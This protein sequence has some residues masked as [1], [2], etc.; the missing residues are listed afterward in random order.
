[1]RRIDRLTRRGQPEERQSLGGL[2]D[3]IMSFMGHGYGLGLSPQMTWGNE[4]SEPIGG[5]F[6]GLADQALKANPIVFTCVDARMRLFTEARFKFRGF[7][8]GRPGDL[9][10]TPALSLL[11]RP[12]A[13]GTTGDL[14]A[15]MEL[16]DSLAGNFFATVTGA[17]AEKRIVVLRPDWCDLVFDLDPNDPE[18]MCVGLAYKPGGPASKL[19]ARFYPAGSFIHYAPTPDPLAR[20]RGMSWLTPVIREIQA[21]SAATR[22]KGKFFDNA[23]TPNLAVSLS[24]KVTVDAFKKFVEI[25]EDRGADGGIEQAY[26][27]LWLAG[28]ADV[29]V[30]GTD[31]GKLD[32]KALTGAGETR[33][34]AAAG[35]PPIVGNFSEGLEAA[36]YSNYA[37]ARRA[38]GDH[39][40]RPRWRNAAASLAPLVTVPAGTELWYD[41]RDIAFLREDRKDAAEIA[42]L[43]AATIRQYVDAGFDPASAVAAVENEDPRLLS[44]TGLYSVQLQAPGAATPVPAAP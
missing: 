22:H 37:Q 23:A 5:D 16:H 9:Y 14:L 7:N 33:I 36:T 20:F 41:D 15:R 21:D 6:Q 17:G 18:A 42:S 12:W 30:I 26:K 3:Q 29:T 43:K 44:H 28:G 19:K 35:L 10:G 8:N 25:M 4:P 34:S 31:L 40:A 27:T 2:A 32:Y 13:N 39:W 11:E 24:E 1:V 38:F